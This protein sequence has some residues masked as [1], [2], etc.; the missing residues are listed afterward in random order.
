TTTSIVAS[1]VVALLVGGCSKSSEGDDDA[2]RAPNPPLAEGKQQVRLVFG[3]DLSLA[4]GLTNRIDKKGKKDPAWVFAKMPPVAKEAD[5]FFAN[6]EM[7]LA[8]TDAGEAE[9]KK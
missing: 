5:L 3:G 8:D 6:V 1:V 4:R 9:Q 2:W 7:V